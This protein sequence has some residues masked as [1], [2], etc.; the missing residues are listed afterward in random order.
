MRV[1]LLLAA[2]VALASIG[3]TSEDGY[4]RTCTL[5]KGCYEPPRDP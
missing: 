4:R 2:V 1:L 5:D 3:A